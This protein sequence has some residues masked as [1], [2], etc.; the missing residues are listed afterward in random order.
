M[1]E[2]PRGVQRGDGLHVSHTFT[3]SDPERALDELA[4][5]YAAVL[6]D[7]DMSAIDA[8]EYHFFCTYARGMWPRSNPTLGEVLA[9][10]EDMIAEYSSFVELGPDGEPDD[11]SNPSAASDR[12]CLTALLDRL[13]GLSAVQ[14]FR[15]A[16][17]MQDQRLPDGPRNDRGYARLQHRLPAVVPEA[18][19]GASVGDRPRA[20]E[21]SA[22]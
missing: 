2:D 19:S 1:G 6:A 13:S 5:R 11:E 12:D 18:V 20:T 9:R 17:A 8:D 21:G 15:L 22:C 7:A 16:E 3:K 14:F 4:R 10:T